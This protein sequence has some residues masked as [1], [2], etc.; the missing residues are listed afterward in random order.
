MSDGSSSL[1]KA[2]RPSMWRRPAIQKEVGMKQE[3]ELTERI[4]VQR[5]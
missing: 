5:N 3:T 1:A 4:S 2:V